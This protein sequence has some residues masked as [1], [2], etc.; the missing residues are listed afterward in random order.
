MHSSLFENKCKNG[1][2]FIM[3]TQCFQLYFVEFVEFIRC[4]QNLVN[5]HLYHIDIH[6]ILKREKNKYITGRD[7]KDT[8]NCN[9]AD[10]ESV[11]NLVQNRNRQHEVRDI[12]I[13]NSICTL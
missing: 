5:I 4:L 12:L 7:T 8:N 10:L 6:Q 3:I 9:F 2:W 13:R 11:R 1:Y